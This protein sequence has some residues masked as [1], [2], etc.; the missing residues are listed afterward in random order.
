MEIDLGASK[1]SFK[2]RLLASGPS[3]TQTVGVISVS[4]FDEIGIFS[5]SFVMSVAR[6]SAIDG[7]NS[8]PVVRDV[9]HIANGE[10][11]NKSH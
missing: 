10:T 2:W 9:H 1:S 3:W 6:L 11:Q 7:M 8:D 4:Y 5:P